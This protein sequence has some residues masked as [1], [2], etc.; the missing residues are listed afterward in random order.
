MKIG[1]L[2]TGVVGQTMEKLS[3]LWS[4]GDDGNSR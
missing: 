1:I 3:Q 4:S 2:G